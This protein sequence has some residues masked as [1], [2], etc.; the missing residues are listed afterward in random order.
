MMGANIGNYNQ[1]RPGREWATLQHCTKLYDS[2]KSLSVIRAQGIPQNRGVKIIK[3]LEYDGRPETKT[4]KSAGAN[5]L[6]TPR[7]WTCM[8]KPWTGFKFM[9]LS[10]VFLLDS[11]AFKRVGCD[12]SWALFLL[13]FCTVWFTWILFYLIIFYCVIF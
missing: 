9:T 5:L 4:S 11:W 10:L 7:D 12:V 6:E 1:T 2:R 3:A 8:Q 13:L